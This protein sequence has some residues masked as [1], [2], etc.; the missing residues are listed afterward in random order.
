ME[1]GS[2]NPVRHAPVG[3]DQAAGHGAAHPAPK[4]HASHAGQAQV[5]P[6]ADAASQPTISREQLDRLLGVMEKLAGSTDLSEVLKLIIDSLRDCLHAERA[7]VF[8]YDPEQSELFISQGHGLADMRFPTTMG[9]AGESARNLALI[10]VADCY[11]DPRFNQAFD[12]KSGYR[13]RNMLTIPLISA[14][15]GLQGVAQV[16][17][18]DITRGDRFD[19]GDEALARALASQAAVALRRAK[20]LDAEVRKKKIEADLMLARKIQQSSWP[21][22]VPQCDGYSIAACSFPADETGGDTY[23]VFDLAD[24]CRDGISDES[25]RGVML[26]MGD[27]TGHGVGPALSVSQFRAMVRMGS[28]L[29]APVDAI[30]QNINIQMVCDLPPGRFITAFVGRFDGLTGTLTYCSAGQAPLLVVR[31]DGRYEEL[32][33]NAMPLGIDPDQIPEPV[34]PIVLA[35]GD[36]FLMLSD[37]YFEAHDPDDAML[38]VEPIIEIVRASAA[39]DATELLAKI[40]LVAETFVRGRKFDDDRT[41]II[42]KRM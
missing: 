36:L 31:A 12:Q 8:Q 32:S 26:L 37:G 3:H 30:V 28:R 20:L 42:I 34:E 7:S 38:G 13:T 4:G 18:K 6:A 15:T 14:D 22:T 39:N 41:A 10:N 25:R 33:A 9:I 11:A 2:H 1:T 35:P 23:D 24:L 17:N 19:A 27:A 40:N 29:G 16:L 21:Q 5:S